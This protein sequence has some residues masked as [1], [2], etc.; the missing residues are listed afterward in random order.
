LVLERSIGF[1]FFSVLVGVLLFCLVIVFAYSLTGASRLRLLL[2]PWV[3]RW[4]L[5]LLL[6]LLLLLVL[7]RAAAFTGGS[8][9]DNGAAGLK[10]FGAHSK[11]LRGKHI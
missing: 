1:Q 10:V 11:R 6:L 4:R 3:V 5:V 2:L 7:L 8:G 9:E